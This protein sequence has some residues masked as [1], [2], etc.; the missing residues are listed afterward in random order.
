MARSKPAKGEMSQLVVVL[1]QEAKRRS[2]RTATLAIQV[3]PVVG[4]F[5]YG[6]SAI[7]AWM[8]GRDCPSAEA[9]L[10]AANA[11]DLLIDE[12]LYGKTLRGRMERIEVDVECD[13]HFDSQIPHQIEL[14]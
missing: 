9:L 10:A 6:D 8:S 1:V 14:L 3:A 7:S 11:T 5:V 12:Y 13:S 2:G 4:G